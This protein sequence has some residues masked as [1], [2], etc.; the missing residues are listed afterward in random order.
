MIIIIFSICYP[1]VIIYK[2]DTEKEQELAALTEAEE[3]SEGQR[4]GRAQKEAEDKKRRRAVGGPGSTVLT[5]P[6]GLPP[7][8]ANI[9]RKT[10]LG[11]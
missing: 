6:L 5:S 9:Q 2:V 11:A 1:V 8:T 10:A 3:F 4:A 7:G